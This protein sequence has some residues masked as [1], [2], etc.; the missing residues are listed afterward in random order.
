M[1]SVVIPLYNKEKY[2]KR[3]IDSV[4][5]QTMNEFE[6]VVVDDGSKDNGADVVS[7]IIDFRIVVKKKM[8]E[9]LQREIVAYRSKI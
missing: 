9:L 3:A 2:I 1:V 4:L 8:V 6:V 7:S 5:C